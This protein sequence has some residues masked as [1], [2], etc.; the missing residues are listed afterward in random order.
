MPPTFWCPEHPFSLQT[1]RVRNTWSSQ[2]ASLESGSWGVGAKTVISEGSWAVHETDPF[3]PRYLSTRWRE[4]LLKAGC[5]S[6]LCG[7]IA[8]LWIL[9]LPF[10]SWVV[11]SNLLKLFKTQIPHQWKKVYLSTFLLRSLWG[12]N[13][14]IHVKCIMSLAQRHIT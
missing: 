5:E 2:G 8:W 13:E 14:I 6:I 10:L 12:L 9:A 11:L 1:L 3:L 4:L 7:F